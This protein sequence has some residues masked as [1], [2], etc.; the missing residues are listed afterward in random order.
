MEAMKVRD[1]QYFLRGIIHI[2][3]AYFGGEL[4]GGKAGR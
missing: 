1:G 4:I 3:D 2:D